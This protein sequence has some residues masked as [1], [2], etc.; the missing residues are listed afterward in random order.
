MLFLDRLWP[1]SPCIRQ[2]YIWLAEVRCTSFS[3]HEFGTIFIVLLLT[4]SSDKSRHM[5]YKKGRKH[6]QPSLAVSL[7]WSLRSETSVH[8]SF[9]MP[10]WRKGS[11]AT[12]GPLLLGTFLVFV[13]FTLTSCARCTKLV[14]LMAMDHRMLIPSVMIQLGDT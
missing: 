14:L 7:F 9:S 5:R 8:T 4:W 13:I 3:F 1:T 12:L 6:T 10:F 2:G 11:N